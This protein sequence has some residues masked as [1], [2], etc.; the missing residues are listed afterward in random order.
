MILIPLLPL[1]PFANARSFSIP[2]TKVP[3]TTD[4]LNSLFSHVAMQSTLNS[5][6]KQFPLANSGAEHNVPLTDFMNAQYFGEIQIGSPP[7]SFKVVFDTGSSNLWVPSTRCGDIACWLHSRYDA[8][9]SSTHVENGTAFAIQ[10]GTGSLEGV[11]SQDTVTV[12]D[13]KISNQQFAE[14]TK[15]PGL[16]FAMG[17]FDGILGLGFS[18]IAVT[19]AVPPFYSMIDQHLLDEPL[20]GVYMGDANKG[21]E[22]GVITFG[23]VD[24]THY[25]GAIT[26]APV[27]RKAYWEVEM[28]SVTFGGKKLN[29]KSQ[30]AAIDTGSSLFALPTAE[31]DAI[32]TAIGATKSWNGQYTVNCKSLSSL[33]DLGLTFGGKVFTLTAYDYVL[34][35]GS[36]ADG[37]CISGFLGLEIPPPMGP[38]WIV[39]DVFLRKYYTIY[40]LGQSRVGFATAA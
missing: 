37:Q 14:S 4:S 13:L 40:D 26:W 34:Q 39:G 5:N 7:Q 29:I 1:L 9:K 6:Y 15:E 35:V 10:Y 33:P 30:R 11:I 32:N 21:D 22:G 12:G 18:T 16:T 28:S 23:A 36:G 20:L 31:A 17:R 25:T 24:H 2:L 38:L 3:H 8:S 19:G 27:I